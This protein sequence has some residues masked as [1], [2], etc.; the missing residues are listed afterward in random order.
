MLLFLLPNFFSEMLR[1]IITM[2]SFKDAVMGGKL[3]KGKASKSV[4]VWQKMDW[5]AF[6][7]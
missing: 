6:T 5:R 1:C 7:V 4:S 2:Y 3:Q